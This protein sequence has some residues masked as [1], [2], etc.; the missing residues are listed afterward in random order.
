K[1][2]ASMGSYGA[3]P[4]ARPGSDAATPGTRGAT[5]PLESGDELASR[6]RRLEIGP[7]ILRRFEP[8]RKADESGGGP[9]ARPLLRGLAAMAGGRGV[10]QRGRDVSEAR[11]EWDEVESLDERVGPCSVS[12]IDRHDRTEA[13]LEH[14]LGESVIWMTI[15]TRIVHSSH[16][17]VRLEPAGDL[18][19]RDAGALRPHL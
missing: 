13:P 17:R 7:E 14:A 16:T 2:C 10:A 9:L 12:E 6:D 19:R 15:E 3:S 4:R 5:I 1:P 18:E 8:D 11:R